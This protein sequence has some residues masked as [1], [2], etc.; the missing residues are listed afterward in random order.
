VHC[1]AIEMGRLPGLEK[2]T[3]TLA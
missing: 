1:Q 3:A 2:C